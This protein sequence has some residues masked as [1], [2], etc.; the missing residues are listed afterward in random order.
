[1]KKFVALALALSALNAGAVAQKQV[2]NQPPAGA[3]PIPVTPASASTHIT[4]DEAI[5]LA[6]QH[7]HAL[8]AVRTSIL[9]SQADEITANLRP[10]PT[11]S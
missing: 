1:M 2:Q 4:L 3:A 7:N 5:R 6:V 8:Q 11:I 10:N 9:V